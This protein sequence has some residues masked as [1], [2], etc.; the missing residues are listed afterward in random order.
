M[1]ILLTCLFIACCLPILS[2]IPVVLAMNQEKGGYNNN[3]PR[4]QQDAL[5]GLGARAVSGHKNSY[6]S[7]LIFGLCLL[8]AI[9]LNHATAAI[10]DLAI[11]YLVSR[12]LYH[13][14]YLFDWASVRSIMWAISF[15]ASLGILALCFRL[16]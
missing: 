2:K 5:K 3:Y 12:V 8:P 11:L 1:S 4:I 13:I 15:A 6:E 16:N 9:A 14:C 10:Q 7:L